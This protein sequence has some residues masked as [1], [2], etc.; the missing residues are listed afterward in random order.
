[1]A[2]PIA[3]RRFSLGDL[4]VGA[5]SMAAD[6]SV[7]VRA[8]SRRQCVR[9][10]QIANSGL[11]ALTAECATALQVLGQRLPQWPV[12]LPMSVASCATHV[13]LP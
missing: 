3:N 8:E 6:K 13:E 10:S 1:M 5:R 11:T 12:A 2:A 9:A 7:P 4:D